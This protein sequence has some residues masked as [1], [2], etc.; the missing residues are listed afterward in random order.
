MSTVEDKLEAMK[1]TSPTVLS[2]PVSRQQVNITHMKRGGT[3]YIFVNN[4]VS[5]DYP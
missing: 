5:T 4:L 2:T 3:C 1:E